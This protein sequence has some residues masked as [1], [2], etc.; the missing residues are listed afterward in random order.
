MAR[1]ARFR[2]AIPGIAAAA[3]SLALLACGGGSSTPELPVQKD[4]GAVQLSVHSESLDDS[5]VRVLVS[6][7]DAAELYQLSC[8]LTFDPAVVRPVTTTRGTLVDQR[9]VFFTSDQP[10]AYVPVAF[11]YH[12][13]EAIPAAS[14][15]IARLEFS[16]IDPAGNPGFGLVTDE[17]FLIANDSAGRRLSAAAEVAQ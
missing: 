14:G 13:G 2:R 1:S 16:V 8:R 4:G 9:A 12:P 11:T 10:E 15:T 5:T 17:E 3:L 6:A 7:D